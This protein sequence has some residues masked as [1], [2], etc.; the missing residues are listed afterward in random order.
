MKKMKVG[1]IKFNS[2]K[3]KIILVVLSTVIFLSITLGAISCILNYETVEDSLELTMAAAVDIAAKSVSAE[4]TAYR[5]VAR[6]IGSIRDLSNESVS[7]EEKQMILNTRVEQYEL[8]SINI[9]S[10][11]GLDIFDGS[12]CSDEDYFKEAMNGNTYVDDPIIN[13]ADGS[14]KVVISAPVWKDG[15]P[16]TE[17]SGVVY[18][19]PEKNFLNDLVGSIAVGQSDSAYIL[20]RNGNTIAYEDQEILGENTQELVKT[21]A[22]FADLAAIEKRMM[23][24]E[25]GFGRYS[26]EGDVEYGAFATIEGTQGW[27]ISVPAY[28]NEFL[29]GVY[30]S[31]KLIAAAVV[32]FILIG[33]FAAMFLSKRISDPIKACA[34]RLS[35]LSQGDLTSS[36]P[37]S[38]SNDE[39]AILLN[40][41]K[42]T[43]NK[44][45]FA[46]EDVSFHLGQIENGILSDEFTNEYEGDFAKLKAST[47]GIIEYLNKDLTIINQTSLQVSYGSD[48]VAAGAQA[49]SQ[50][51]S[52]QAGSVEELS[53]TLNEI[54]ENVNNNAR[55][56][57][58]ARQKTENLKNEILKSNEMMHELIEAMSKI[59]NTSN[60]INK[61]N[62]AI[63]DIA[64]QTNILA[65][66]AAVEAA[67]AGTAGK[68]FA[69]VAEEVRNLAS[70]SS[71]SAKDTSLLIEDSLKAVD[72]GIKIAG[73]TE[74]ALKV[75]VE[76]SEAFLKAIDEIMKA[77][78]D[79]A[80]SIEQVT[81]GIEQISSV[82]QSNSATAEESAAAS[83]ELSEQ[84]NNLKKLVGKYTLKS[85]NTTA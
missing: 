4:L 20:D 31:I 3:S 72:D 11:E 64:F 69:V 17:V 26:Y 45:N 35:L 52:E 77:T 13:K 5:N 2:I 57:V 84:S 70:K 50:G 30:K 58:F 73:E 82:V 27:S 37:V 63:E 14:Y 29:S 36:V 23:N 54:S 43:I 18:I 46:I 48:Q 71:A 49:L 24:G 55:N 78:E 40:S 39:T 9:I 51:T 34:E 59:S 68:G 1:L 74:E 16:G 12:N 75:L 8:Q 60:K 32:I 85:M 79:Q 42:L 62:K 19:V 15:I 81:T 80:L 56:S 7:A 41:L 53:A 10:R 25:T 76:N 65:L 21:D 22:S 83:Q 33:I 28:Q 6:E 61:I 66:N 38:K 67:R 47:Q 44:I